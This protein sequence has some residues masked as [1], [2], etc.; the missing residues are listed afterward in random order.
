MSDSIIKRDAILKIK[1][2]MSSLK[3][4]NINLEKEI[5]DLIETGTKNEKN[6]LEEA[7]ANYNNAM[8]NILKSEKVKNKLNEKYECEDKITDLMTTVQRALRKAIREINSQDISDEE[9]KEKIIALQDAIEDAILSDNEKNIL[10][11]IKKQMRDLP[12]QTI[13]I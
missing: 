12:F 5:N 10:K 3:N 6:A 13:K 2:N 4:K 8:R 1:K 11:A 7:V 9:K